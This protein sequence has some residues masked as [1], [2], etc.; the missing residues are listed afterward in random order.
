[1]IHGWQYFMWSLSCTSTDCQHTHWY[2]TRHISPPPCSTS[3]H[4]ASPDQN[5]LHI[6]GRS[7]SSNHLSINKVKVTYSRG[8][9]TTCGPHNEDHIKTESR[10]DNSPSIPLVLHMAGNMKDREY[11]IGPWI[12][13]S[14]CYEFPYSIEGKRW[15][16][17]GL[18]IPQFLWK[19]W[20]TIQPSRNWFSL[21]D[22]VTKCACLR[23]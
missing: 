20:L 18:V 14:W 16:K 1:M 6:N 13:C 11:L 2:T 22:T 4:P 17:V 19:F 8:M 15:E 9:L 23:T 3:P 5:C 12:S 10:P 21:K 7:W